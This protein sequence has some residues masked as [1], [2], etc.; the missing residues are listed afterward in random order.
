MPTA[1]SNVLIVSDDTL[2]TLISHEPNVPSKLLCYLASV[3]TFAQQGIHS[4]D[5]GPALFQSHFGKVC[6]RFLGAA[7]VELDLNS[8]D[9]HLWGENG[10][11]HH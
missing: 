3:V 9:S 11:V 5:L 7:I 4:P 8:M 1:K 2:L 6:G 10:I